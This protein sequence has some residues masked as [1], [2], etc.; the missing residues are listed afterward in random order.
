VVFFSEVFDAM[1][2]LCADSETN[3]QNAVQFLDNLVKVREGGTTRTACANHHCGA[4][5]RSL[6]SQ[7][8]QQQLPAL[9]FSSCQHLH[10]PAC[11]DACGLQ[12][13]T[14]C[15]CGSQAS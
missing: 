9:A 4:T 2:R 6:W 5:W 14:N 3:V 7:Q 8:Q 13:Q 1:F 11:G 15:S 10:S 12:L